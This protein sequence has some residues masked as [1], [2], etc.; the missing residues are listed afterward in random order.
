MNLLTCT[1]RKLIELICSKIDI[2]PK[3]KLDRVNFI[4][5]RK[6]SNTIIDQT[7]ISQGYFLCMQ[8]HLRNTQNPITAKYRILFLKPIISLKNNYIEG[9]TMLHSGDFF[10]NQ[11][12]FINNHEN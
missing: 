9:I 2:T 10:I 6:D 8:I 1:P 7:R 5:F 11:F 4:P 12:N 3:D